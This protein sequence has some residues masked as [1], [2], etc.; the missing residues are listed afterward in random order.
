[1]DIKGE[2]YANA[3]NHRKSVK[4]FDPQDK[5]AVYSYDPFVFLKESTNPAQEA[6]AIAQA[7]IPLPSDAKEP[8]WIESAQILLTGA[9][10]HYHNLKCTF[11]ETLKN[12]QRQSAQALIKAVAESDEDNAVLC[13]KSFVDMDGKV[14]AGIFTEISRGIITLVTD[15][16]IVASL[17][18]GK[19]QEA[20]SPLDLESG[21]DVYIK[22]S[23]HLLR[24]WKHLLTLMV[25][26]FITFLSGAV[27]TLKDLFCFYLTNFPDW[28]KSPP[29]LT[30]WRPFAV[31]K[32]QS[33]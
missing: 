24:Q 12:I 18:Q 27:K 1:V 33:A 32:S 15:N 16:D 13:A 22:I 3:K 28:V 29:S 14:L 8:F 2:L 20:I 9:I 7:I 10:L 31:K 23:E 4:V 21:H 5:N 6:R 19:G 25:N 26:Q 30:L 17:T 11:I